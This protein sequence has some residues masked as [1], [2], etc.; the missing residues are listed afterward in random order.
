MDPELIRSSDLVAIVGGIAFA[1]GSIAC[2]MLSVHLARLQ[3]LS[4]MKALLRLAG[5]FT[6]ASCCLLAATTYCVVNRCEHYCQTIARMS[7]LVQAREI[8]NDGI[9]QR[10][11]P[12]I[13]IHTSSG[14]HVDWRRPHRSII[15]DTFL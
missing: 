8:S 9:S 1:F 15:E 14:H 7:P 12:D 3:D 13:S 10:N 2:M 11:R 4:G 5:G 6:V